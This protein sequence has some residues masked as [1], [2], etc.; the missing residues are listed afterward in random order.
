MKTT[1]TFLSIAIGLI[2]CFS[3]PLAKNGLEG[4]P[5]PDASLLLSDSASYLNTKNIPEGHSAVIF[6]FSPHC[7]YCRAQMKEITE[8]S[9]QLKNTHIYAMTLSNFKDFKEFYDEFRLGRYSNITAGIDYTDSIARYFKIK[10][11]PFTAVFN[12]KKRLSKSFVGNITAGKIKEALE[13]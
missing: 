2:G 3:D 9:G 7:P 1:I 6:Y 13:D 12:A 5:M 4:K 8:K 11:V 10:V